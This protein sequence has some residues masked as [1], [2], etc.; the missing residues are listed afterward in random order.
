MDECSGDCSS[1]GNAEC[2]SMDDKSSNYSV[3]ESGY[4]DVNAVAR[5]IDSDYMG[6]DCGLYGSYGNK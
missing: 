6:S 2:V 4:L 3:N 5:D 1:C